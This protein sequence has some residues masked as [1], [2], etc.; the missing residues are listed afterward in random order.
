M[1]GKT[2]LNTNRTRCYLGPFV[3]WLD[4]RQDYTKTAQKIY[5]TLGGRVDPG[6]A[7]SHGDLD[8]GCK[9]FFFHI[10]FN[11]R[12]HETEGEVIFASACL[13]DTCKNGQDERDHKLWYLL[14]SV[15]SHSS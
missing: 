15:S 8:K 1:T 14:H 9:I 2:I 12:L 11:L 7:W 4:C 3:G 5:T 13:R 6:P 10:N